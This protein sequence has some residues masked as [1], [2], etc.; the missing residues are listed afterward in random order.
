MTR[1]RRMT[2]IVMREA[3][4]RSCGSNEVISGSVSLAERVISGSETKRSEKNVV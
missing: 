1:L 4:H 3:R 2:G